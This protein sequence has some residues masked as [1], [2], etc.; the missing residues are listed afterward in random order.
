MLRTTVARGLLL[1]TLLVS[2]DVDAFTGN[3]WRGWSESERKSYIAGTLDG[4]NLLETTLTLVAQGRDVDPAISS[5]LQNVRCA[6]Q[7]RMTYEQMVGIV[8]KFM[9]DHPE[10]WQQE[11]SML[12]WDAMSQA[13]RN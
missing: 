3:Q 4:W 7:R 9:Q 5:L 12:T 6:Q 2:L 8:A 13:C 1:A 10:R 11:M